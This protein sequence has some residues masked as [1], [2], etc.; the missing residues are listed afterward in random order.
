MRLQLRAVATLPKLAWVAAMRRDEGLVEVLH[1]P[2]VETREDR[3]FEGAWDGPFQAGAFDDA[4]TYV[5]SGGRI[6]GGR[7]L[8]AAP[9]HKLDR[10]QSVVSGDTLYFS[11][12]LVL[13]LTRAGEE[14][15]LRYSNY[16]F[17]YLRY[18]RAGIRMKVKPIRLRSGNAAY[19]HDCANIAVHR[20]LTIERLEK[21]IPPRPSSYLEYAAFLERTAQ[22]VSANATDPARSTVFPPL[23]AI[24]RGYD[25]VAVAALAS[26]ATCRHA[27]TFR[28]SGPG[29]REDSGTEIAAHLG[30]EVRE[31]DRTDYTKLPGFPEV[32]FFP[33]MPLAAKALTVLEKQ[34]TGSLFFN[35]QGGE[36]IW[37]NGW[38]SGAPLLQ[39]P[40]AQTMSGSNIG[41]FRLRV[42]FIWFPL[43]CCGAIHAPSLARISLSREMRAWS[44]GGKYDR[45]IPRR[46]A[47]ERGVPRHLF[48][49]R[50][51]GGGPKIGEIGLCP[52][53]DAAF[54]RFCR[55]EI[56]S[57]PASGMWRSL[58]SF[59][60]PLLRVA[61]LCASLPAGPRIL[62][63]FSSLTSDRLHP[64]W[65]TIT[66]YMFHWGFLQLKR[67]YEE[68]LR[69]AEVRVWSKPQL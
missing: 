66:L 6:D 18:F 57:K 46:L 23:A 69:A 13:L 5:G 62:R 54:R 63:L 11:N 8:F 16:F 2:W 1:G 25:S 67:R 15:D 33:N 29:M 42:G 47:E 61:Q 26:Q 48:G 58:Y 19:L 17:D 51:V 49:Q 34:L 68:S 60:R 59:R 9:T 3:F 20:D 21:R 41:E 22:Q 38:T 12:S 56:G 52:A 32:E 35:G 65:G 36:D 53:S 10:I 28:H 37:M 24:S 27:V 39:E 7:M 40:V 4:A 44:V 14:I 30:M 31:F 64:Y 43:A 50:K 55:D 45:P